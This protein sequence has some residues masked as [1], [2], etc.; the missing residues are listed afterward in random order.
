M[1]GSD[2]HPTDHNRTELRR[3]MLQH[4]DNSWSENPAIPDDVIHIANKRGH[5]DDWE[6]RIDL[7]PKRRQDFLSV[8]T[9]PLSIFIPLFLLSSFVS[10]SYFNINVRRGL[11]EHS[12]MSSTFSIAILNEISSL[13]SAITVMTSRKWIV[14]TLNPKQILNKQV[15]GKHILSLHG[16][17]DVNKS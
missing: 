11:G 13:C 9:V 2:Q 8:V 16:R 1:H 12:W 14:V 10:L 3:R 5:D 6:R 4:H 7:G 15:R 17:F